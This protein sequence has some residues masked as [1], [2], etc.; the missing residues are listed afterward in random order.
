[1]DDRWAIDV[2]IFKEPTLIHLAAVLSSLL[3][4]TVMKIEVVVEVFG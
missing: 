1:M 4:A 3:I 2:D